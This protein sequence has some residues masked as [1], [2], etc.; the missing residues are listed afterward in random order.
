M[1]L[2]ARR[3]IHKNSTTA[4]GA[5]EQS[6]TWPRHASIGLRDDDNVSNAEVAKGAIALAKCGR[7]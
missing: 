4:S 1:Y 7:R 3:L 6:A 5:V 2:L